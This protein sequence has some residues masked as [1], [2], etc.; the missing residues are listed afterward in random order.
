MPRLREMLVVST[1]C[2]VWLLASST[3]V[4]AQEPA[5]EPAPAP[6]KAVSD[7]EPSPLLIEPK[8][9]EES[10]GAALLMVDLARID[11]ALKYLEQFEAGSPDDEMLMKLRDKQ[12]TAAFLKLARIK[13]LQPLSTQLLDRLNAATRKQSED[14]AFVD[15]LIGRLGQDPVQRELAIIELRNAGPRA[16]PQII[17]QMGAPNMVNKQEQ[18]TMALI[19]MGRQ[20]VPPLIGALDGPQE[21]VRAAII[22]ILA[23]LEAREAVPYLWFPAFSDEQPLGVRMAANE[24]L[25]TLITGSRAKVEQITSVAAANELRRLSKGVYESPGQLPLQEDG[26]VTIWNWDATEQTVASQRFTPAVAAMLISS[27]FAAQS[28]ALSPDQPEPQRQYLASL[29]GLEVLQGGWEKPRGPV[30]GSAFYLAMTAGEE[31]VA[32]VLAD[33]LAADQPSTAVA[34]L[35]VLAQIGTREQLANPKGLKSPV[36]AALNSPDFRIQFAAAVTI[37]RIEPRF[38]FSNANR[39]VTVLSRA[40]TDPGKSRA[41]VIDADPNRGSQAAGYLGELGYEASVSSTGRDGFEQTATSAGVEVILIHV[42]CIRWDLTQTL[43]NF[44]ADSRTAALPVVVYGTDET[45]GS[46]ARL[47]NRSKPA[48]FIS[49]SSTFSDFQ[50]QFA[51][52]ARDRK[53]PPL[54]AQERT[55]QKNAAAY[56]LAAIGTSR[57]QVFDISLAERELMVVAEDQDIGVNAMAAMSG[58]TSANVQRRLSKIA[59]NMQLDP[60]LQQAAATQLGF[61]IQRFGLLLTKDEVSEVRTGW[62]ATENPAVKAALAS[63]MGTLRPDAALIGERLRQFPSPTGRA[64]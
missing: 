47:I 48:L 37:L 55:M 20:V 62:N 18:L 63:V 44:R 36:L 10:F 8:T 52:F 28:L 12:G 27:R 6:A 26:S 29:L 34:A 64:N 54:S 45:R 42:N 25:A 21:R 14:P 4:P 19:R 46:V 56:W 32:S 50:R 41:I 57:G 3:P 24:A 58:I 51:P 13:E 2:W 5:T 40:L 39:V 9:P 61:H 59:T 35:E 22:G 38:G 1:A 53:S 43:A 33:A 17:R 16:V 60:S 11:L 31:T 23:T 15:Q 49:E 30:P 7:A